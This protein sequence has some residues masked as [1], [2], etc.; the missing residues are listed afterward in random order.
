MTARRL[1]Q[2][3][4]L[5]LAVVAMVLVLLPSVFECPGQPAKKDSPAFLFPKAVTLKAEVEP[6]R[7]AAR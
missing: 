4:G 5:D 1:F 6:S 3:R 2:R 7:G